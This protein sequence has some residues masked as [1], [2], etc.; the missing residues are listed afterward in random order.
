MQMHSLAFLLFFQ[1]F[2]ACRQDLEKTPISAAGIVPD[3]VTASCQGAIQSPAANIIFRS[4]DGGQTWDDVSAG[5][6]EGLEVGRIFAEGGEIFLTSESGLYHSS[7]A[8]AAPI[9][10]KEL[11]LNEVD[12]IFPGR[13]GP[14]TSSYRTGFFQKIPGTDLWKPM[15][16]NLKDKTVR[17]V[18]ETPDGAIFVGCESGIFKSTDGGNTWKHVF[19][20]GPANCFASS[21]SVL[22]C[23]AFQGMLRSTDGGEHW[24][25][26]LTGDGGAWN[27]K[28]IGDRFVTLTD[29][30]LPWNEVPDGVL[31]NR[32]YTSADNGQTWQRMDEGLTRTG[33]LFEL[34][35]NLQP[36][37]TIN[38]FEQAGGYLFCSLDTGIFRSSDWGKTWELVRP[39]NGKRLI[40]L[41]VSGNVIYAVT[42]VGC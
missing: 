9:W 38:D 6:P 41:A 29:G 13:D 37:R 35:A 42:V 1:S 10:E 18:M 2:F 40:N 15:H 14:Y 25:W 20:E 22:V 32:L 28:V 4:M 21:G 11:F 7:T 24:D 3:P 17:T 33:L 26:A 27:T 36:A 31:T 16:N 19:S 23:G 34:A 5:L 12:N 39:S 30:N 8:P